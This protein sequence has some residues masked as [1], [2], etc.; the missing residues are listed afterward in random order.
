MN[1]AVTFVSLVALSLIAVG[2]SRVQATPAELA[3]AKALYA[4]ASYEEALQQLSAIKDGDDADQVD[5]YRALCLLALGRVREA[6]QPLEQI[7]VRRPLYVISEGDASPKL[8]DLF[9][10]V[11]KRALPVAA[12]ELYGKARASYDAKQYANAAAQFKQLIAVLDDKEAADLDWSV[13]D[14][15]P[16]GEGFLKLA[17]AGLT[18]ATPESPIA[19]P[20]PPPAAAAPAPAA[21][22]PASPAAAAP[23]SPAA[24]AAAAPPSEPQLA[25]I[26]TVADRDVVPPVDLDRRLPLW[27]PRTDALKRGSFRGTLAIVIDEHGTVENVT[28]PEPV[29]PSYDR[30]LLMTAKRWKFRPATKD[31]HPVKYQEVIG[32]TLRPPS[33]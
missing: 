7:I 6:E 1:R 16:L 32:I 33:E 30:D 18:S 23:A 8:V 15:K 17:E 29:T 4:S 11:R 3:N 24:A 5:Q 12:R 20:A 28:L 22:A 9:R 2:Q 13:A 31:G 14:L 21:A 19:A 25:K 26:Y 10:Q 27:V